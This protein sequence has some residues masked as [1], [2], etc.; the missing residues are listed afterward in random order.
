[1]TIVKNWNCDTVCSF[2]G[3]ARMKQISPGTNM[4]G[5]PVE[6]QAVLRCGYCGAVKAACLREDEAHEYYHNIGKDPLSP[7]WGKVHFR[8][9]A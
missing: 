9:T 4:C 3:I 7:D 2:C 5:A 1:M 8:G 6:K